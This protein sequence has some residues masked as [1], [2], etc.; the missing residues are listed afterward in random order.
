[1]A[2]YSPFLLKVPLKT[3]QPTFEYWLLSVCVCVCVC[4]RS[5]MRTRVCV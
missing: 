4:M 1:V 2:H 5:R 3:K